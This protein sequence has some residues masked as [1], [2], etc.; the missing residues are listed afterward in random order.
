MVNLFKQG[1]CITTCRQ[2]EYLTS[3]ETATDR[4]LDSSQQDMRFV[5]LKKKHPKDRIGF[6]LSGMKKRWS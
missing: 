3:G 5:V 2:W 6:W 4:F 1:P